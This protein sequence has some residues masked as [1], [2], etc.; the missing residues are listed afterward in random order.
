[1][2]EIQWR[3]S[4][5]ESVRQTGTPSAAKE[6]LRLHGV[7]YTPMTANK[8]TTLFDGGVVK[9][10]T[11]PLQVVADDDTQEVQLLNLYPD[12]R[13]QTIDGFGGAITEAAGSVLRQMPEKTAEKILRGYFGPE[14][15]RYSFVRTHLD[16]CDFSLGNYSAVTDPQDKEFKTF[17][18]A[19]DE[20]YILPYIR[21]A[22]QYAGHKIGVMLTPWSPPAFMKTNNDRNHGGKLLP[23][24]ADAWANYI[25]RYIRE[26]ENRG[27]TVEFLTVQNEPHATQLWDSC[28][29]THEEEREFLEKHLYPALQKAGLEKI[30]INLWDHNK[31]RLFECAS[32]CVTASTNAMIDG[33][34][35]HWYSGDHFDAVRLV[36]EQYPDKRLIFTEGCIEYS[37]RDKDQLKNAQIYAHDMIGNFNAGMNLFFDWNIVLDEKGGPNHVSNLC[38]A[39]IMCNPNTKEVEYKLSYY[40]I[41]QFSH[42]VLPGAK[43]IAVTC[44]TDK[45]ETVA[46]VN[47]DGT[48]AVVL[49]NRTEQCMP[50]T[51]RIKGSLIACEIEANS[52]TTIVCVAKGAAID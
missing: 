40:Y 43:R 17:S 35:F 5:S 12:I 47:P 52:M 38:D 7:A 14:G 26:Y 41:A 9:Q 31:E 11:T 4:T 27:I 48:F 33:F 42:Y 28:R 39:P 32:T 2:K 10:V 46:F 37:F 6:N 51:L 25:C 22:E 8:H 23:E 50:V 16:S 1:M 20:K 24:Y 13:Y 18:L 29:Y 36:R 3:D 49:L 15:L 45:L 21:L 30:K 34:A 19:R 44:Y